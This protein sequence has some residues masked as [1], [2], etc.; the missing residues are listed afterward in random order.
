M[1]AIPP[2]PSQGATNWYGHYQALDS[3]VRNTG[4]YR[5]LGDFSG[6]T[7]DD[8]LAAFM[9]YAGAQTMRG[10]TCVL[11]EPRTY[12]FNQTR[13]IYSGFSIAGFHRPQD[14]ARSSAPL[15]NRINLRTTGGWFNL[16]SGNTFGCSFSNLSIDGTANNRLMDGRSDGVLWTSVFRDIS[17]Q[18]AAGVLGSTSQKLLNTACAI[19]GWWNINNVRSRAFVLGGSDSFFSPTQMLIDSPPELLAD[20]QYLLEFAGQSKGPIQRL[21]MTAEGHSGIRFSGGGDV[22]FL[23]NCVIEGRNAG[24]PCKGA[25]IRVDSAAD[26]IIRDS[27]LS[28]AMS[29]P[30]ATGRSD[31]GVL[32]FAAGSHVVD[33]CHYE[34]ATGVSETVPFIYATGS[35]RVRVRNINGKGFSGKPVVY[36]TAAG[37]INADDSVTVVTA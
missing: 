31:G 27:W 1:P 14:Q 26:L 21:Y 20:N 2:L 37:L 10:I 29:N 16:P 36:Q 32:H 24:A 34:R 12:T 7:D 5:R 17:M 33:G 25:L 19:D 8:K 3:T 6:A 11:D 9:S 13:T 35:A 30:A 15:G 22:M 28:Y 18:N 4:T 23:N